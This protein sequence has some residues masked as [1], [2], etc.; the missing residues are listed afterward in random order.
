MPRRPTRTSVP[1]RPTPAPSAQ[2]SR[3]VALNDL[4][5]AIG[6]GLL[7]VGVAGAGAGIDDLTLAEPAHGVVGQPGDLVLGVAVDSADSAADLVERAGAVG[8]GGV[9]LRRGLARRR[10]VRDSARRS[11]TALVELA[12][13]A[14][15]AHVIWLLRGVLDRAATDPAA[16]PGGAAHDDLFALADAA[17]ALVEAPV[18]IEDAH[19]RVLAYS[20]LQDVTDPARVSTIVGRRVPEP[21]LASLRSRGVFRRLARSG[22][23]FLV[24]ADPGGTSLPRFV[25]PVRAGGEWLGSIWVV[26]G[27]RP[28][29]TVVRELV[30]TASVVALHLLRLRAQSDLARRVSAD[31]LRAAL[32]GSV[33]GA[34]EWL[35][36]GPW[37]VVCLGQSAGPG[38]PPTG[39]PPTGAQLDLWES[40]CRRR[41]WHQPLLVD[42]DGRAYAVVRDDLDAAP[43]S[44]AWL[45]GL[46][47][48]AGSED[49]SLTAAAGG[50][51]HTP[52]EL[53]RSRGEALEAERV[54]GGEASCALEELWAAVTIERAVGALRSSDLLGPLDTLR[55][56][57]AERGTGYLRTLTEW[58]DHQGEPSQAARALHVHPN[59]LRYRMGRVVALTDLD[60]ADPQVRLAVRLQLA[61]IAA[62]PPNA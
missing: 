28:Q 9:V 6:G 11:G 51:A 26:I 61:V 5:D 40:V 13:H 59:T 8:A 21:V 54:R 20:S 60:L 7:R 43:G 45:R 10:V 48:T 16:R 36:P 1:P 38:A 17:A 52:S 14:S 24:P 44:W 62:A 49:L 15:W 4:A 46:V 2:T 25:V 55:D 47:R 41:A 31:R 57:D 30:Q 42:L 56:H 37:R 34:E 27:G 32:T 23:P 3:V 50:P 22:E 19:S 33:S 12:E 18:T 39:A 35:A 53:E 29:E 58:L